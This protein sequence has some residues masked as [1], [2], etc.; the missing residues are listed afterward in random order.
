MESDLHLKTLC[1]ADWAGCPDTRKSLIGYCVFLGVAL[2]SWRSKKQDMVSRSSTEA[3]YRFMATTTCKVTLLL[4]LLRNL[5]V[6]H[7]KTSFD[8]L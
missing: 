6:P 4:Y 5:H 1:D 7:I 2:I 8:V 3:K